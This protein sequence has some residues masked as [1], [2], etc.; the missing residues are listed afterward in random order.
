MSAAP[1]TL[2][3]GIAISGQVEARAL[4]GIGPS[5]MNAT[6]QHKTQGEEVLLEMLMNN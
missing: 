3:Q 2:V 5:G 1:L 6:E 4:T